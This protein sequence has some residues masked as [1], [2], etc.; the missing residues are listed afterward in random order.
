MPLTLL[1]VNCTFED[2]VLSVLVQQNIVVRG[3]YNVWIYVAV[4][5]QNIGDRSLYVIL[6]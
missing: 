2:A 4:E 3:D 6:S 5:L 1:Q